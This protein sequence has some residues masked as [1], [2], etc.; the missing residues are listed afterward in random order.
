M[1]F[2]YRA[3]DP[4]GDMQFGRGGALFLVDSPAAVAQSILTRLNL[5]QGEW[6]LDLSEGTP[7]AQSVL[8]KPVGPGLPDAAIRARILGTPFVTRIDSYSAAYD[9][10]ARSLTI[11]ATVDTSFGQVIVT[12][13]LPMPP[14]TLDLGPPAL[15][16]P[17]ATTTAALP[18]KRG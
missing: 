6:W 5:W 11:N 1:T 2:R 4:S 16:A 18:P 3:L 15:P 8:G 12:A 9:S 17:P 14:T 10:T 13:A 7:W